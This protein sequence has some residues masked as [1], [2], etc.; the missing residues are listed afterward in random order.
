MRSLT[1]RG[2]ASATAAL[3]FTSAA[4]AGTPAQA[5]FVKRADAICATENARARTLAAPT[6][7]ATTVTYLAKTIAIIQ[8]ART[9]TLV[10]VT[11]AADQSLIR[12]ELKAEANELAFFR[13]AKSAAAAN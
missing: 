12:G 4:T 10:L 2:L 6:S 11:P 1:H 7:R 3:I 13:K 5:Q 9:A 8:Q